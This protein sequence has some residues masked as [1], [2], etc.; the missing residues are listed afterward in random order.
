MRKLMR[1]DLL[2][3]TL[4]IWAIA[5]PAEAYI[6]PGAGLGAIMITVALVLGLLLLLFG[7]V[8]YPLRRFLRG[9]KEAD[10]ED[11]E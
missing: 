3:L 1:P 10:A 4:A 5:N 8:W 9:R 11:Q 7:F 6:G 2:V